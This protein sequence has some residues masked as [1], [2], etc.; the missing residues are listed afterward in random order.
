MTFQNIS[1]RKLV[2]AP[3]HLVARSDEAELRINTRQVDYSHTEKIAA[4]GK[5][6]YVAGEGNPDMF[7]KLPELTH[8][9]GHFSLAGSTTL[10]LAKLQKIDGDLHVMTGARFYAPLLEE[11]TGFIHVGEDATINAPKIE[12]LLANDDTSAI[13]PKDD[14]WLDSM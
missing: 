8:V 12:P 3:R 10:L 14:S 7:E 9:E 4:P 1:K 6:I 11:V 2:V 5:M 13:G